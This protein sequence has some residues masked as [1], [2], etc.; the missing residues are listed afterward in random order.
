M[1]GQT[2]KRKPRVAQTRI[3]VKSVRGEA[4]AGQSDGTVDFA[5]F[6]GTAIPISFSALKKIHGLHH[7]MTCILL[8]A[9]VLQ[10]CPVTATC[11]PRP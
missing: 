2:A 7:Y 5:E 1:T 10:A 11:P 9:G 8:D 4:V 6:H 3:S